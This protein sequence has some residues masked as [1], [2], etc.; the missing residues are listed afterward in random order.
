MAQARALVAIAGGYGER[1]EKNLVS[2]KEAYKRTSS[3]LCWKWR[4]SKRIPNSSRALPAQF[5]VRICV[6]VCFQLAAMP[7]MTSGA[8]ALLLQRPSPHAFVLGPHPAATH[9]AAS[10][11]ISLVSYSYACIRVCMT[12]HH[13]LILCHQRAQGARAHN[14]TCCLIILPEM[15]PHTTTHASSY[16]ATSSASAERA[17][18]HPTKDM[19]PHTTTCPHTTMWPHTTIYNTPMCPHTTTCVS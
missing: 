14:T 11:Q 2:W 13:I 3:F 12:Q 1:W 10:P 16:Y 4:G 17:D 9:T 7:A 5:C 6:H 8:A 15:C 18:S 19:C